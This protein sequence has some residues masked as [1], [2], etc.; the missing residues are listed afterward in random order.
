MK[1][2][3]SLIILMLCTLIGV[4]QS[5][6]HEQKKTAIVFVNWEKTIIWIGP[7]T[8]GEKSGVENWTAINPGESI[9]LN[10]FADSISVLTPNGM[11]N[12]PKLAFR[13]SSD[14]DHMTG[15]DYLEPFFKYRNTIHIAD[16]KM[17]AD[18]KVKDPAKERGLAFSINGMAPNTG[19]FI[20]KN[21]SSVDITFKK[22]ML[23]G[24][25]LPKQDSLAINY[26][27]KQ[28][29]LKTGFIATEIDYVYNLGDNPISSAI[30]IPVYEN[31]KVIVI[32]DEYLDLTKTDKLYPVKICLES[33]VMVTIEGVYDK[34]GKF[35]SCTISGEEAGEKGVI[36][37]LKEGENSVN[38]KY[39]TTKRLSQPFILYCNDQRPILVL[40]YQGEGKMKDKFIWDVVK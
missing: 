27:M 33:P 40:K 2:N 21:E 14:P 5:M 23:N 30:T 6:P 13:L 4:A 10:L 8:S 7:T 34:K 19:A 17:A 12:V 37:Y 9:S 29:I 32:T 25:T 26:T 20:I 18:L 39:F 38:I 15:K 1:T 22:G 11:V 35:G 24:L 36:I 31:S 3:I 28:V 16:T